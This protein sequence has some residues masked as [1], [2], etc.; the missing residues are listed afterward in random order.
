[1]ELLKSLGAHI[2]SLYIQIK[3]REGAP[4]TYIDTVDTHL[5]IKILIGIPLY[6]RGKLLGP[7]I[8]YGDCYHCQQEQHYRKYCQRNNF[9]Y[10]LDIHSVSGFLAVIWKHGCPTSYLT[11]ILFSSRIAF[12]TSE[13]MPLRSSTLRAG[14]GDD[15]TN[16]A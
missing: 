9:S 16:E 12:S 10:F 7:E 8:V 3:S 15:A 14:D 11:H 5:S 4:E 6:N 13:S 2:Q 1:M